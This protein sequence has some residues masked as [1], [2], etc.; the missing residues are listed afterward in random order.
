M[1]QQPTKILRRPCKMLNQYFSECFSMAEPPL[2]NGDYCNIQTTGECPQDILWIVDEVFC[3]LNSLN[4]IK[5]MVQREHQHECWKILPL[6]SLHVQQSYWIFLFK[7]VDSQRHGNVL[8]LYP[9][10]KAMS[11]ST[12][13]HLTI[14]QSHYCQWQVSYYNAILITDPFS[15]NPPLANWGEPERAP[16]LRDR[17]CRSVCIYMS[18]CGHNYTVHTL[19]KC[20]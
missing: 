11:T 6:A 12:R 3:M 14:G 17:I 13:V 20:N 8:W 18:V 7:M 10:P 1:T 4:T 15:D 9:S 19:N 16:H 5:L 2:A